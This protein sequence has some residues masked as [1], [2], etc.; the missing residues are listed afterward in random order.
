MRF[1]DSPWWPVSAAVLAVGAWLLFAL[2]SASLALPESL[3]RG[4]LVGVIVG[5]AAR[6]SQRWRRRVCSEWDSS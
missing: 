6:G 3:A 2:A 4:L 1:L 5:A